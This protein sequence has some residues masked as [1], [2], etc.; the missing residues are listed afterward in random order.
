MTGSRS[1]AGRWCGPLLA[2]TG[3][4]HLAYGLGA[5]WD[6]LVTM[7]RGG[8]NGV[9][10]AAHADQ[11]WFWF[12]AAGVPLLLGGQLVSRLHRRT[13]EVPGFLGWY[14]LALASL[15][16]WMPAG[17]FWLFLPQAVL[18]FVASR[19]GRDRVP[20]GASGTGEVVDA[21]R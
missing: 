6:S 13:G 4:V 20:A 9:D 17:G 18:A 11:M 19:P 14:L 16:V 1:D 15:V 10:A 5:G 8:I 3:L 2:A 21:S 7:A 12:L